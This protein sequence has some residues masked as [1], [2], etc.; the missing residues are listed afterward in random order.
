MASINLRADLFCQSA[1]TVEVPEENDIIILI[2][3]IRSVYSNAD[4]NLII[5]SLS[6]LY[7]KDAMFRN[8]QKQKVVR[9]EMSQDKMDSFIVMDR[10]TEKERA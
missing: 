4:S 8:D 9:Q 3:Y 1:G 7:H 10:L 2:S 6:D 5:R